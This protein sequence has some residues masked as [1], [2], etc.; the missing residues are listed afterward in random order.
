MK[1]NTY[2]DLPEE[3]LLRKCRSGRID[4]YEQIMRR[5]QSAAYRIALGL[6]GN[7]EES[8]D[9]CQ[10]AFV[11]AFLSIK[12]VDPDRGFRNWFFRILRNECISFLRQRKR[13]T[14]EMGEI[15]DPA[16]GAEKLLE[17]DEQKKLLWNAICALPLA[18]RE[19]IVLKDIE[20]YRYREIAGVLGIP[21]GTVMSR[22][23]QGRKRLRDMLRDT[24]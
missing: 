11:K 5:Y 19:V 6:T 24:R 22:L 18:L 4:A 3:K 13:F 7:P 8:L 9:L 1:R 12:K 2:K 14:H 17:R 16:A 23:H 10:E 20:G 21:E 15:A